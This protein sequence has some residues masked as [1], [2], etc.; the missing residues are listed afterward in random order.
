MAFKASAQAFAVLAIALA[1]SPALAH[2]GTYGHVCGP[3]AE[4]C[5]HS[6]YKACTVG[7]NCAADLK[8]EQPLRD[9]WPNDLI[10]D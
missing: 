10:L 5:R 4:A 9:D 3:R 7:D 2:Q 8:V 6:N 1:G